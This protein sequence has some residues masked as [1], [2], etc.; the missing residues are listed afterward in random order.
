MELFCNN[1]F[2][3]LFN[4]L[5]GCVRF[6][7]SNSILCCF[8][9]GLSLLAAFCL[10]C[11]ASTFLAFVVGSFLAATHCKASDCSYK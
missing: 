3:N 1:F 8:F 4:Y 6:N 9:S 11:T 2:Y 10:F 7:S 5:N